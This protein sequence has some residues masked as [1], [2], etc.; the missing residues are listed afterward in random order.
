MRAWRVTKHGAPA[1]ALELR[2]DV[3]LPEP[4]REASELGSK[5]R[6]GSVAWDRTS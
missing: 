6:N 3:A 4:G 2:D 5:P 1:D